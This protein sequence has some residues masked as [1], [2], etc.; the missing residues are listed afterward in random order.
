LNKVMKL[1]VYSLLLFVLV[2]Q[3]PSCSA[4][5]FRNSLAGSAFSSELCKPR[6]VHLSLGDAYYFS[7][8]DQYFTKSLKAS[9]HSA[10][11]IYHTYEYCG[12][13][14]ATILNTNTTI[15]ATRITNF[16]DVYRDGPYRSFIYTIY[17]YD[18]QPEVIYDYQISSNGVQSKKYSFQVPKTSKTGTN[19]TTKILVIG[20]LDM[21]SISGD[22]WKQIRARIN[23]KDFTSYDAFIH[24]GDMAYNIE[25]DAGIRGDY[26]M[27]N[28]ATI[29][30]WMPYMFIPGNHETH[31]NYSNFIN[32]MRMP[33]W[34]STKNHMYSM[35]IG[36]IHFTTFNFDLYIDNP[37]LRK[38]M[39]QW[40]EAD[41]QRADQMR[42]KWP[43][44]VMIN[45]KPLYCSN[46]YRYPTDCTAWQTMGA[47]DDLLF[48]YQVDLW[49]NGHAHSYER[50]YP[51]YKA[52]IFDWDKT[53]EDANYTYIKNP[54]ATVHITE[55]IAGNIE[56]YELLPYKNAKYTLK[57][58]FSAGYGQMI[59]HNRTHLQYTHF[60]SATNE[61]FDDFYI[62]KS[63][64]CLD[65]E[66]FLAYI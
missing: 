54:K 65:D 5:Y 25:D 52:W 24:L 31:A 35:N 20:D 53:P 10:T 32:R 58:N 61:V 7:S 55:A 64:G 17:I 23:S 39:L 43:W 62:I 13:S 3:V 1:I 11:L 51:V 37:S 4:F 26:F 12:E 41:L 36:L 56:N 45:H 33:L 60:L 63:N 2:K 29:S 28:M 66:D 38:G 46:T 30:S 14:S 59:A 34:E 18:L 49:I 44:L 9:N 21:D 48:K 27:Q 15:N 40:L 16:T 57:S 47:I 8:Q 50:T 19:T 42:D 22:T 6:Q